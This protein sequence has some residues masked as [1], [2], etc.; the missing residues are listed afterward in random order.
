MSR[1]N[2]VL[3]TKT[4]GSAWV[5]HPAVFNLSSASVLQ[6]TKARVDS[7]PFQQQP[8]LLA[9]T[10]QIGSGAAEASHLRVPPSPRQALLHAW[11]LV[12][13]MVPFLTGRDTF[14]N[15]KF[16]AC[17]TMS[18]WRKRGRCSRF[19]SLHGTLQMI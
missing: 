8:Q 11:K 14:Y 5:R 17:R 6:S 3:D 9:Y 13:I 10:Y 16:Q 15:Y 19:T 18:Y 2:C 1:R 4:L 12:R 7:T